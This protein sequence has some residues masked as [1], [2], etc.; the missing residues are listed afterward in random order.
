MLDGTMMKN[1]GKTINELLPYIYKNRIVFI[2]V[3]N[4]TYDC[5]IHCPFPIVVHQ[6]FPF[7]DVEW[8]L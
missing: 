5:D 7:T 3:L 4:H 1:K 8:V 6:Y 2:S